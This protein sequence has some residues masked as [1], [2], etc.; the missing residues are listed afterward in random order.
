MNL[1]FKVK[2]GINVIDL[3]L[4]S[5]DIIKSQFTAKYGKNKII[6]ATKPRI[7]VEFFLKYGENSVDVVVT[8][9]V[10]KAFQDTRLTNLW[11]N[12]V[13]I[14]NDIQKNAVEERHFDRFV[15]EKCNIQG[16]IVSKADGTIEN[17]VNAVTV[18]SRD[19]DRYKTPLEYAKLPVDIREDFYT[20]QVG[21]FIVLSEVDDIVTTSR[22]FA[23]L[24][25]KYKDNG[26]VVRSVSANI[27]RMSVDNVT[28]TNVG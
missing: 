2:Y 3:P 10:I 9:N 25:E 27:H 18:I 28:I 26:I 14:F 15:I 12:K 19:V 6:F 13:T 5:G 1:V 22:E 21:S 16:G 8:E 17:I 23:E 20:A 7:E 24:Q 11:K 4:P